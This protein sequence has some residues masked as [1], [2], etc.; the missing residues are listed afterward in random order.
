MLKSEN[1]MFQKDSYLNNK[2][3]DIEGIAEE[4]NDKDYDYVNKLIREIEENKINY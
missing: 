1:T 3:L 2:V 4:F